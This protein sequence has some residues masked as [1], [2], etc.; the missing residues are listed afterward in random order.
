MKN[1]FKWMFTAILLCGLTIASC[2]KDPVPTPDPDPEPQTV[3]RLST[4]KTVKA[5][6]VLTLNTSRTLSWENGI[7]MQLFDTLITQPLGI[8]QFYQNNMVYENGNLVRVDEQNGSWQF[9]FTYEDGLLKTFLNVMENDTLSWGEVTAYTADGLVREIM[10]HNSYR[11][12]RW[13]ITRADGDAIEVKEEVLEP[14]ELVATRVYTNTYD[15]NP[16]AYTGIPLAWAIRDGDGNAVARFM[17]KHNQIEDGY[18]YNYDENDLLISIV[19]ENDS[20]FRNYI[21]QTLR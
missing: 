14:E 19:A 13:T 6:G 10:D 11:L 7:L 5:T 4:E 9:S 1:T 18:T 16:C 12:S 17:S 3:T 15:N 2:K 20:T 21:E 8:E